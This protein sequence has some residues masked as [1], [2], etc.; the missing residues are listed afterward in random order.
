MTSF[1]YEGLK[2]N[3][4]PAIRFDKTLLSSRGDD[5]AVLVSVGMCICRSEVNVRHLSQF[6]STLFFE[7]GST[8]DQEAHGLSRSCLS[9]ELKG[10]FCLCFQHQGYSL[11]CILYMSARNLNSKFY[12]LLA[13]SLLSHLWKKNYWLKLKVLRLSSQ[14]KGDFCASKGHRA[15]IRD[16]DRS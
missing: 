12:S 4:R 8:T 10:S 9:N 14:H 6:L 7:V 11:A 1:A 16:K 15:G 2:I 3:Q 13:D 5:C